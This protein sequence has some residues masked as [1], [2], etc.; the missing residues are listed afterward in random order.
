MVV[1]ERRAGSACLRCRKLRMAK[2]RRYKSVVERVCIVCGRRFEAAL[3]T[4]LRGGGHYCSRECIWALRPRKDPRVPASLRRRRR[5]LKGYGL[6]AEQFTAM[7]QRQG[8][9]CL[10]C[11]ELPKGRRKKLCVDHCHQTNEV[12][13]LLCSN[14]N[15]GLGYFKDSVD[16]LNKAAV[17]VTA[18]P[19]LQKLLKMRSE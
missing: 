7:E 15:T 9:A 11:G 10:V 3:D 14:C 5:T 17:Y 4:V 8:G 19:F 2:A 6:S 12:R 13:G 16:L 18:H 1:A